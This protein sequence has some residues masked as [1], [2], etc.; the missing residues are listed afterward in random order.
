MR[1]VRH[2]ALSKRLP[3]R[4]DPE[5]DAAFTTEGGEGFGRAVWR[6]QDRSSVVGKGHPAGGAVRADRE[7][8]PAPRSGRQG[9]LTGH[10]SHG[11]P[12][13]GTFV[14]VSARAVRMLFISHQ[15]PRNDSVIRDRGRYGDVTGLD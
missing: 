8:M 12:D 4:I 13:G 15:G 10:R 11:G 6:P 14:F 9:E 3:R 2:R 5:D 7:G 1:S